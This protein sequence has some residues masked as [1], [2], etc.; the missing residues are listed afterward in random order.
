MKTLLL[1][2]PLIFSVVQC[3]L[4]PTACSIQSGRKQQN[5]ESNRNSRI[6]GGEIAELGQIP[7]HVHMNLYDEIGLKICSGALINPKWVLTVSF[8]IFINLNNFKIFKEI[9]H[10]QEH[11]SSAHLQPFFILV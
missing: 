1:L 4:R 2:L 5:V 7:W 10:S 8:D 9:I 6:A 3:K 11:A